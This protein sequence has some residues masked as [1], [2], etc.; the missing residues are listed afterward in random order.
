[1][2]LE[3]G[4]MRR[5]ALIVEDSEPYA[6]TLEIALLGIR[7]L[8]VAYAASGQAAWKFLNGTDGGAVCAMLTDLHM[9]HM[10]GFEL[11]ERIRSS[12]Q[13]ARLPIIVLSGDTDPRTP[14]RICALGADAYFPKPYSP[15][16]VKSK[17]EQLLH[18]QES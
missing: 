10:D 8:E 5:I 16:A 12:A 6:S 17:L 15:T 2:G 14:S 18:V 1:V 13:H 7:G 3:N 11:I 9:P 4:K